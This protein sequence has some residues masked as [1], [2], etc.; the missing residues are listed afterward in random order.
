MVAYTTTGN[1]KYSYFLLGILMLLE[2]G[3][4]LIISY[5]NSRFLK[6]CQYLNTG[7]ILNFQSGKGNYFQFIKMHMFK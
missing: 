5:L 2:V 4:I 7:G 6:T 1:S 3:F